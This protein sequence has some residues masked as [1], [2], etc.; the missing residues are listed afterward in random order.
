MFDNEIIMQGERLKRIRNMHHITQNEISEG[1]CTRNNLSLIENNRQNLSF[2]LAIEL[3][4]RFNQIIEEK[5]LAIKSI[6][7]DFLM[8]DGNEQANEVFANILKKLEE[9]ETIDVA[10]KKLYKAEILIEKYNIPDV[11]KIELYKF[12]ADIYYNKYQYA[13]SNEMC[14]NGLKI[15]INSKNIEAEVNFY[16]YISR[17]SIKVFHHNEALIELN[18]AERLNNNIC[19]SEFCELIFY[20]KGLAYK[21]L[22]EYDNALKYLKLL[23]E[24][25][26]K[27]Q[28][29]LIKARIVYANCLNE[30]HKFE[31]AEKEYIETLDLANDLGDKN[32]IALS[33]K[34]LSELY[35][36]GKRYKDAK[37]YIKDAM[38]PN[39]EY[40]NEIYYFAAKVLQNL[41]EDVEH[42]LLQALNICERSDRENVDLIEKIIYEL[43]LIYIEEKKE[44]NIML[45][46]EKLDKL[47]IDITLIYPV[48]IGY[49][50]R[51][52]IEES[53]R[54]NKE[55]IGK[56][57]QIKKI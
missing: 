16:L 39:N 11:K 46:V 56:I 50:I 26:I 48:I 8:K 51:E 5:G 13:K 45:M 47:N 3:A 18:Y 31:E 44:T 37:K 17:N 29:L 2:N 12:M 53:I 25:D 55:Y 28:K 7:A 22:G 32:F 35:Y 20:N 49:Y 19:N 4:N 24:R 54:L 36:N 27:N 40:L 30:Q 41:N 57:K 33:Y 38:I 15:C 6:T 21:K 34:N 43:V 9:A 42:Y 23:K 52:N 1:I 10:E 14:N